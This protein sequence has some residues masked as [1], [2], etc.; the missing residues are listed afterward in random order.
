MYLF[1]GYLGYQREDANGRYLG[2]FTLLWHF[3][4]IYEKWEKGVDVLCEIHP[5]HDFLNFDI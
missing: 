4:Y 5:C 3:A 2:F 1:E